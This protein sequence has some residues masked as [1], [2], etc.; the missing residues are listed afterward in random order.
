MVRSDSTARRARPSP[1]ATPTAAGCTSFMP[2][3]LDEPNG[4]VAVKV[5]STDG[6]Y[7]DTT[8]KQSDRL[9]GGLAGGARRTRRHIIHLRSSRVSAAQTR[10]IDRIRKFRISDT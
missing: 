8:A 2:F 9:G 7:F 6:S 4:R 10:L 5:A 3:V 1:A